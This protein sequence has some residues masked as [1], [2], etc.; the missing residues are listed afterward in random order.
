[1]RQPRHDVEEAAHHRRALRAGDRLHEEEVVQLEAQRVRAPVGRF[2]EADGVIELQ[3][4][5]REQDQ[6]GED[7]EVEQHQHDGRELEELLE[8]DVDLQDGQLHRRVE[9]QRLVRHAGDGDHQVGHDGEEDQPAGVGGVARAVDGFE[10]TVGVDRRL[11]FRS[12]TCPVRHT[13]GTPALTRDLRR[14]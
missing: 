7:A 6:L 9:Q 8:L 13:V 10:Q 1:M 12:V 11:R 5:A 4:L 2:Q 3:R 14:P